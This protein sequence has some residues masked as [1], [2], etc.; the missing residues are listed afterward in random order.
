MNE[1]ARYAPNITTQLLS[2]GS[3][4]TIGPNTAENDSE[5]TKQTTMAAILAT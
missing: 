2:G 1:Q 5:K 4:L 3:R